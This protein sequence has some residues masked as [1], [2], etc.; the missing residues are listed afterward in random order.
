MPVHRRKLPQSCE[1]SLVGSLSDG[2]SV[3]APQ[4]KHCLVDLCSS[5]FRRFVGVVHFCPLGMC[6]AYR[7]QRTFVTVRRTVRDTNG[8]TKL[9]QCLRHHRRLIGR[10]RIDF[11]KCGCHIILSC[12]LHDIG[13]IGTQPCDHAQNVAVNCRC[14]QAKGNGCDRSCCIRTDTGQRQKCTVIGR[15]VAAKILD[16]SDC[17]LFEIPRTAVITESLPDLIECIVV[18]R[19]KCFYRRKGIQKPRVIAFDRF[20]AR[21]LEHNFRDPHM[22]R[23]WTAA[24]WQIACCSL[25]PVQKRCC[26]FM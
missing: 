21:L 2:I 17:R 6:T 15:Q 13:I 20:H 3:T 22:V 18:R 5:L 24:P 19:G 1:Q 8:C 4:K 9:H 11:G 7:C 25:I 14:R 10:P 26:D 12:L 16:Q 23:R